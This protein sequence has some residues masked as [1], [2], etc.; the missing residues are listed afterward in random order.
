MPRTES[1]GRE[2]GSEKDGKVRRKPASG[3]S[4][5]YRMQICKSNTIARAWFKAGTII[6]QN[7]L[8]TT[9]TTIAIIAKVGT[10][11]AARKNRAECGTRPAAKPRHQAA[12]AKWKAVN[13]STTASFAQIHR[14]RQ[15]TAPGVASN[16]RPKP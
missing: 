16:S 14:C 1:G 2:E 15:S 7:G 9:N 13:N 3:M 10:S 5:P 12:S 11:L 4:V 6:G 8:T